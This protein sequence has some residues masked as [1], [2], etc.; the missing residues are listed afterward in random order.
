MLNL[1]IRQEHIVRN[2]VSSVRLLQEG[3][4]AMRVVSHGE[5]QQ[6]LAAAN[7]LLRDVARLIVEMGMRPEDVYTIRRENVHLE[8]Q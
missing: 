8:R 3:P 5:Q 1:V 4:G 6:Y 2:P 7:S